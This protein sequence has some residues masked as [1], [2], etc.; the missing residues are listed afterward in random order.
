MPTYFAHID[1]VTPEN[2]DAGDGWLITEFRLPFSDRQGL[3]TTM[4]HARFNPGAVHK[5]HKHENCEEIY[6]IVSGNG[7]AGAGG[8]TEEIGAGHFH[9][10]PADTEHWLANESDVEPIVVIGWYLGAGS[11]AS[12][13][14]VYMG[15]VTEADFEGPH[16][17]YDVGSLVNHTDVAPADMGKIDGWGGSE[18]RAC[19]GVAQEIFHAASRAVYRPGES[20]KPHRYANANA[21]YMVVAGGGRAGVGDEVAAI[22]AGSCLHAPAG[23]IHWFESTGAEPLTMIGLQE[24]AGSLAA[25]GFEAAGEIPAAVD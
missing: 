5:K 11:V 14:Y 18:F 12:T 4:F 24:G 16:K 1:D 2:M 15:D 7:I 9:H 25:G 20:F 19:L 17:G 22:R 13:G 10:V 23:T 6:Y 3:G 21:Y 8:T